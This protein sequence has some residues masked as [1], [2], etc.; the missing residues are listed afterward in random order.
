VT[1]LIDT[2]IILD[3]I[4]KRK[5]FVTDADKIIKNCQDGKITGVVATFTIPTIFYI[6][7]KQLSANEIR[8]ILITLCDFLE[9]SGITK[10][11]ILAALRNDTFIDLED[12][13]QAE[14]AN[15]VH[16]DY[17]VTRNIRDYTTSLTPA[18][19]PEDF[20]KKLDSIQL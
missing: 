4:L 17:I 18:I 13:L 5:P 14:S 7:S 9:V 11:Q 1:I 19:L 3:S 2:N 15:S 20:L 6:L 16:A 10:N 8:P 12:C